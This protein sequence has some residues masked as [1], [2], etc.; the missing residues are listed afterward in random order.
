MLQNFTRNH[1]AA[2]QRLRNDA[3]NGHVD[4][5]QGERKIVRDK[6]VADSPIEDG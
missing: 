2:V 3:R 1:C 4:E 5:I 6:R